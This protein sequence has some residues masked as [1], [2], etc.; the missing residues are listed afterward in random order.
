MA[1]AATGPWCSALAQCST[2][3]ALAVEGVVGVGDVAG[4]EDARRAGLQVL[5]DEDAV[6]DGEPGLG[7]QP[8]ARLHADADDHEVALELA[9]V[10]GADALDRRVALEGL[11]AGPEQHLHAVVEVDV[12]VDGAH[13]GAE[14]ALERDGEG[15]DDRDLE[16]A[17]ARRGGDLGADPAGPDHD[18]RAAAVQSTRAARRSRRRC[19]GRARRRGRRRGSKASAARRPWRAA[20]G[21]SAAARRR[22]ASARSPAAFRLTAVRPRRSSMSCSA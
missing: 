10:A 21:R 8:G 13:L 20:A 15:V 14:H 1:R 9:S 7:G 17:L 19:A 6:V 4:G 18:D 5:V 16:A 2:R 11:D 12:A 3:I 22:R